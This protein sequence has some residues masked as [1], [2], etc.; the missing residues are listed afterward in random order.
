M[1]A[2]PNSTA[3]QPEAATE[4]TF[5]AKLMHETLQ[6]MSHT[7]EEE[8]VERVRKL[9]DSRSAATPDELAELLIRNKVMQAGA[10]G[11]VTASPTLIPGLGTVVALT[12]G[13]AVDMRMTYKLQGELVLELIELYQ[14]N[15]PL[16]NKRNVLMVVTGLSLGAGRVLAQ[17]GQKVAVEA[18]ERLAGRFSGVAAGEITAEVAEGAA[19]G[20]F[21]KSVSTVLGV[22]TSAGINAVTTYT[23]G[24]RAQ[25][26]L[27]QGPE[28][29][30]DWTAS[31]R[32]ITGVDER[33]IIAWLIAT[34]RSSWQLIRKQSA[35]WATKLTDIGTNVGQSAKE[36]YVVQ[37]DKTGRHLVD[38]GSYIAE[39]SDSTVSRLIDLGRNTGE[40]LADGTNAL[41]QSIRARFRG[42]EDDDN[43]DGTNSRTES[44]P[45]SSQDSSIDPSA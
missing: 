8:A 30:D 10:I 16:E 22:A 11:A 43:Q 14:P 37:A 35:N 29:M 5:L 27:K 19:T 31:L 4:N 24:R 41:V 15:L 25:A 23:I 42:N 28:A 3:P 45:T 17:S 9:R 36:V 2:E 6:T 20:L 33:K 12:F 44:T 21:A 32:T 7:D 39:K 34:T 18:T 13:T 1:M 38:A 26:Y 40:S